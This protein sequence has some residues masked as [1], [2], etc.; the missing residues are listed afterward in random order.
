MAERVPAPAVGA[1]GG[2][3]GGVGGGEEGGVR[4]MDAP[5]KSKTVHRDLP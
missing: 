1:P 4:V 5:P 3:R 2:G